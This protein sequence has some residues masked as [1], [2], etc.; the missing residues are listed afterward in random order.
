M[1]DATD[2]QGRLRAVDLFS[3]LKDKELKK[4]ADVGSVVTHSAGQQVTGEGRDGLGLHVVLDGEAQVSVGG[5]ERPALQ[6][7]S[8]FGE[9][10]LLDGKP[11]SATVTAG[12]A[13]L[14]TFSIT[15]WK[16]DSLLEKNPDMAKPL[17][18][19][20]CA[21]LRAVEESGRS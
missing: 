16:F 1:S 4:L 21:R 19:S 12:A 10:S 6:P 8:Y 11:R 13:G 3:S 5:R 20:L 17:I 2:I 14:T 7:G 18:A 15:S 9:I